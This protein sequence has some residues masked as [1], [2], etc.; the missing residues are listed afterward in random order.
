MMSQPSALADL[1]PAQ[2]FFVAGPDAGA[3]LHAQWASDVASL[4]VGTWQWSAWL[5][6]RGRVRVLAQLARCDAE[7]WLVVLRGGDAATTISAMQPFVFR[8]QTQFDVFSPCH[9]A[10]GTKWPMH[11]LAMLD[12]DSIALGLD[13]RSVM[14][15][16]RPAPRNAAV[17]DTFALA[18]IRAGFA[19][20]PQ[21]ALDALLPPALSLY[22]LGAVATEKGCYPGQEIVSRL[23]HLGGHKQHLYRT[24]TN[25]QQRPGDTLQIEDKI[26]GRVLSV[27]GDETLSVL[28]DSESNRHPALH[29]LERFP[30]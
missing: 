3:F 18:D 21:D 24:R 28:R 12:D 27:A 23:H 8:L 9:C 13:D 17:A 20:L 14:I 22:R 7:R 1:G 29:V 10:V 11:A 5:D 30:A 26:V 16:P 25:Q 4:D 2:A 19:T 6:A 15:S